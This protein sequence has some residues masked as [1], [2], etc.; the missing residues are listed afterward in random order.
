MTVKTEAEVTLPRG[1]HF[2][3]QDLP[4]EAVFIP[5]DLSEEQRM[6]KATA[7]EFMDREV[8]PYIERLEHQDLDL[9][10]QIM[11]KCG[12][13]GLLSVDIPEEYG[14]LG[15]DKV[16][17]AVVAEAVGRYAS[18]AATHGGHTG[19][20]TLP[21]VFFGN[22]AQKRRYLPKLASGEWIAAYAL[23]EPNAG[24]D[25]LAGRASAVLTPDGRHYRLNGT[26]IGITNAGLADVFIVFAK[27]DGE[28]MSCFIVERGFPGV[29]TGKEERKLGI[30][31]S[32]TRSLILEDALVPVENLLGEPGIGHKIALNILNLGRFKLGASCVGGC[33][34]AIHHAARYAA[35]RYQFGQPIGHFG[36]IQH[37]LAE[38]VVRA[39]VGES[40]VYRTAGLLDRALQ[41][42]SYAD[43]ADILKRIEDYAVECSIIKVMMS[44]FL[45]YVVDEFVQ[46]YGG[47]GY[48]AEYPPE[49]AYRDARINRIFEGTNEI[50]RLVIMQMI[51]RK[52]L[53]GQLDLV[54]AVAEVQKDVLVPLRPGFDT[55]P[56]AAERAM[57]QQA[58]KI[59][60]ILVGK[61]YERFLDQLADQQEMIFI[62]SDLAMDI[63]AM[64]SALLRAMKL[65][66][67]GR[68]IDLERDIVQVFFQDVW[69][70][71]DG[72][73]REAVPLLAEGD[74]RRALWGALRKYQWAEPRNAIAA[75]RRI[76]QACLAQK[77]YPLAV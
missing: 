63:Y 68:S 2:L 21:I 11:R 37:K 6:I 28:K 70:R 53:R 18:F 40:M 8:F 34:E 1:A 56:W 46:I 67:A 41:G 54:R 42:S 51:M 48:S 22:A 45:D 50:N 13:L 5:E 74:D 76:A 61:A 7:Y 62:L 49:R 31:G 25:A 69:A 30:K 75:R 9:L 59:F 60:L 4:P 65:E 66:A 73:I 35:E 10:R 47:F 38:M 58:R 29:S 19:I 24:S 23:T 64:E 55:G 17:S 27:I 20:G 72:Y 36:A 43:P 52:T 44:E 39:W 16:S 71:L 77:R 3:I 12:E 57:L 14:G 33:K 26:K 15:L 32:S